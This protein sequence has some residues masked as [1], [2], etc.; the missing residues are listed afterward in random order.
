MRFALYLNPKGN[1]AA[2]GPELAPGSMRHP[3]FFAHWEPTDPTRRC[4]SYLKAASFT[5]GVITSGATRPE[6]STSDW[7]AIDFE[8]VC[9]VE[10]PGQAF[11]HALHEM[12]LKQVVARF[13]TGRAVAA[14]SIQIRNVLKPM[15]NF[16]DLH[17]GR[18]PLPKVRLMTRAPKKSKY[19]F[20]RW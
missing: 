14:P 18:T 20:M 6:D 4:V 16:L 8:Y 7:R 2:H 9:D 5:N 12:A 19:D 11:E 15:W 10:S 3:L 13:D 1:I 17:Q